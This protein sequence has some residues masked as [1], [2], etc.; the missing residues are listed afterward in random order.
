MN[1]NPF[2]IDRNILDEE[3]IRLKRISRGVIIATLIA[4]GLF[5]LEAGEMFF[6]AFL[7]LAS[8]S[9]YLSILLRMA[10]TQ[11]AAKVVLGLCAASGISFL[12]SILNNVGNFQ[13]G[14]GI[15]THVMVCDIVLF[16]LTI[17][18]LL[19]GDNFRVWKAKAR[20]RARNLELSRK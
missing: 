12:V 15:L 5:S 7:L 20:A 8:P 14:L 2:H 16:W 11:R 6:I 10:V 9:L 3:T 18:L 13:A 19:W 1:F 4:E 17:P